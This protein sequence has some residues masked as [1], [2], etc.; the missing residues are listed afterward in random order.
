VRVTVVSATRSVD[1]ALPGAVRVADLVPELARCVGLLDAHTAPGG[2]RLVTQ[3]GRL[4]A[5]GT[6]LTRQ[7]VEDGAVV[8]L[9]A[10]AGDVPPPRYDDVVDAMADVVERDLAPWDATTGRRTARAAAFL[11]LLMGAAVLLTQHGSDRAAMTAFTVA[12]ASLAGAGALSRRQG[13]A[14]VPLA[15]AWTGCGYAAVA[16]LVQTWDAGA[17]GTPVAAA[18]G[19]ALVAG[20]AAGLGLS[21]DRIVMLP[22]V[23]LGAI[24]LAAGLVSRLLSWGTAG[25]LTGTLVAVVLA[26]NLLPGLALEVTGSAADPLVG[27]RPASQRPVPV[28][29][30]SLAAAAHSAHEIVVGVSVTVGLLLLIVAPA[31]VS[32]GPAGALVAV[33]ASVLTMLR[34][35]QYR[36]WSEVFAGLASGVLGLVATVLAALWLHPSW[37][38]PAAVA[39][40]VVGTLLLAVIAAQRDLSARLRLLGALAEGVAVVALPPVLVLAVG[41]VGTVGR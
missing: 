32:L 16:G 8:T 13:S 26:G 31:A 40:P 11:V 41:V 29:V 24:L 2:Y 37:W 10:G 21:T 5:A 35:G 6:G 20:L 22:T 15:L 9:V 36:S 27:D 4:L 33:L 14:V 19:A 12:V 34:A 7:G 17:A 3:G 25:V 39:L 38:P 30:E 23:V 28:D 18:G 1:L